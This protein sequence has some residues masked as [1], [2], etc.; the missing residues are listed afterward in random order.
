MTDEPLSPPEPPAPPRWRS[1]HPGIRFVWRISGLIAAP[2]VAV[3]AA[4]M[5]RAL[6][7]AIAL[8]LPWWSVGALVAPL[9]LGWSWWFAGRRFV[10]WRYALSADD[11]A[12]E[13]GVFWRLARTVPRVRIQHVD[14]HSGPLDRA[15]GL[16]QVS[17][18]TAGSEG[19]VETIPGLEP[20]TAEALRDALLGLR[21]GP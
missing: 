1:L 5:T 3:A 12:V 19:A 10:A 4:G 20:A 15:L 6:Q 18:Y 9:F 17:I 16:A 11:L 7:E 13:H 21:P 8:P 14:L 2:L